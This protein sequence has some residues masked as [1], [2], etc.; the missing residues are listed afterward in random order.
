MEA[1]ASF[2]DFEAEVGE[3]AAEI[4]EMADLMVYGAAELQK[5]L[6]RWPSRERLQVM[7]RDWNASHAALMCLWQH[8]TPAEQ[9]QA[10]NLPRMDGGDPSRP[11][12]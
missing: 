10:P 7:A 3:V 2:N 5:N 8:L 1:L 11:I 4:A 9:R 6:D 12:V